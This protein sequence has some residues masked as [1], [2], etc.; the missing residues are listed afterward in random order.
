MGDSETD[1]E[2]F[3]V[4][5]ASVAMGQSPVEVREAATW[6][7]STNTD[8]GVGRAIEHLLDGTWAW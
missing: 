6:T 4:A 2:M 8:D 7:T 3:K 5:G 1:V